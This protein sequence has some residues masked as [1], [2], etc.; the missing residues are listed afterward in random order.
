[1]QYFGRNKEESKTT[2]GEDS[3]K[4]SKAP[5]ASDA[6]GTAAK[7]SSKGS[8]WK[9]GSETGSKD[10]GPLPPGW[11]KKERHKPGDAGYRVYYLHE[12]SGKRLWN[13]PEAES[14]E[15]SESA[16]TTKAEH[17]AK[18]AQDSGTYSPTAA[19]AEVEAATAAASS[20]DAAAQDSSAAVSAATA[21]AAAGAGAGVS[22]TPTAGSGSSATLLGPDMRSLSNISVLSGASSLGGGPLDMDKLM[23]PIAI[24]DESVDWEA[25]HFSPL[26]E[27]DE[28]L[29]AAFLCPS[30]A[31]TNINGALPGAVDFS[32]TAAVNANAT[33]A[34][35][36]SAAPT[37]SMSSAVEKTVPV[38]ILPEDGSSPEAMDS[39]QTDGTNG[40]S[41]A[42]GTEGA[43]ATS[44]GAATAEDETNGASGPEEGKEAQEPELPPLPEGWTVHTVSK[45]N[46]KSG[47]RVYYR[48]EASGKSQWAHPAVE[49]EPYKPP[50]RDK[51]KEKGVK[52]SKD[53]R[54]SRGETKKRRRGPDRDGRRPRK[55]PKKGGPV[56]YFRS[57]DQAS[58]LTSE[59]QSVNQSKGTEGEEK[60]T[61]RMW[62]PNQNKFVTKER[63]PSKNLPP[64][65]ST[66]SPTAPPPSRRRR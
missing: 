8:G 61:G 34:N 16:A 52:Y 41:A 5:G 25:L 62:D 29:M 58:S 11:V 42:S 26:Q 44:G 37:A 38:K 54:A 3:G 53:G 39:V 22:K 28:D 12:A 36:P 66:S 9:P 6:A 64:S 65:S 48:H 33:S 27:G 31:S 4:G 19:M 43:A 18:E 1:M 63:S 23:T 14:Q 15:T 30:P 24:G 13:R 2:G 20:S 47:Q 46:A 21:T 35:G 57:T 7:D 49:Q 40:S 59:S 51:D 32:T 56:K 45:I 10:K 55:D 50:P 60:V 17:T